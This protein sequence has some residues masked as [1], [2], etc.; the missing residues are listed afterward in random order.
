MPLVSGIS[1]DMLHRL[2]RGVGDQAFQSQ[3]GEKFPGTFPPS[4]ENIAEERLAY[5]SGQRYSFLA[6]SLL[7]FV[8]E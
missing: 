8:F 6:A 1:L 7:D 2:E 4:L 5:A 3:I